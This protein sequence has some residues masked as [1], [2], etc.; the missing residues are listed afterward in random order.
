MESIMSDVLSQTLMD[1]FAAATG[2][3]GISPPRRYLWTDAFAVCNYLGLHRRTGEDRYLTLA[4]RLVD[5]VHHVLGRHRVD[6]PRRGWI[7]GLPAEEGEKH[8][9]RGGLRI[10]KTLN[11]RGPDQPLDSQLEWER[12][13]QYFHYLA[14][15]MHALCRMGLETGEHRYQ[16]WAVELAANAHAAF[17][18]ELFP[19][20]PKRIVWKMSIDLSRPLISSSGQ[21]DPLDGLIACLELQTTQG[22]EAEETSN[23][24]AAIADMSEMCANG[25]WATEDALG[26]GG[27]LDDATRL[28]QLVFERGVER[29]E[30]LRQLLV[31]AEISLQEFIRSS[32]LRRPAEHRLAFRE[33]GLSIGLHGVQRITQLAARDR[34]LAAIGARLLKFQPLAEQIPVFWSNPDH[35]LSSTWTDHRDINTVMLATSLAPESYPALERSDGCQK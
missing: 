21:H 27:L 14:K 25:D 28:A 20:G 15:W 10:G 30:M 6:D 7:S 13:G 31:S 19:G 8:P 22:C 29:H 9:T 12:D 33:L 26:I 35:Q 32:L 3:L 11:E 1:E 5:Q 4:R 18:R 34:E 17:A 16:Q 24:T 23:L 2:V